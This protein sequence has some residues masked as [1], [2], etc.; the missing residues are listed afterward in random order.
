MIFLNV[1]YPWD[2]F[3]KTARGLKSV[4]WISFYGEV[5]KTSTLDIQL[6]PIRVKDSSNWDISTSAQRKRYGVCSSVQIKKVRIT[7][8]FSIFR[9][10]LR[11]QD[12]LVHFSHFQIVYHNT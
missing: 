1:D 3:S 5:F 4:L 8:N 11:Y 6:N 10:W 12:T 7:N 2:K 9:T